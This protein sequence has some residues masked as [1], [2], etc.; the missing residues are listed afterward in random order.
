MKQ[1]GIVFMAVGAGHLAGKDSVQ[2]QLKAYKRKAK[3]VKY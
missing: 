1:P 2:N 3:R